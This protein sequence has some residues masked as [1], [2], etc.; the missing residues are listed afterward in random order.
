MSQLVENNIITKVYVF[1]RA[2]ASRCAFRRLSSSIEGAPGGRM[3][4]FGGGEGERDFDR[5]RFRFFF[6]DFFSF[7]NFFIF[8]FSFE[9]FLI[10]LKKL[11]NK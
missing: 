2:L 4:C 3:T 10:I 6:L 11:K 1:W 7:F 5:E 9:W 8:R